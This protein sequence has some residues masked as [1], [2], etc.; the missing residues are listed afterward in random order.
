MPIWLQVFAA[1][2]GV[3]G[4]LG[5]LGAFVGFG[6]VMEKIEHI[7]TS[8]KDVPSMAQD[9]AYLKGRMDVGV[10]ASVERLRRPR[11]RPL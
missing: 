10:E 2:G 1:V 9:I 4:V 11:I 3:S 7:A 6:R 8:I 5:L